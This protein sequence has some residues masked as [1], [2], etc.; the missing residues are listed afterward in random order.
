MAQNPAVGQDRDGEGDDRCQ[1]EFVGGGRDELG[2][3]LFDCAK[4]LP[5]E[6]QGQ[7]NE[8]DES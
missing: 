3:E 1:R 4:I 5:A 8:R 7:S 6:C 2:Q